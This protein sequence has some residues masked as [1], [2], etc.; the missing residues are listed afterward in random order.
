M[1]I[2]IYLKGKEEPIIVEEDVSMGDTWVN[3]DEEG[4]TIYLPFNLVEKVIE[5]DEE[6][7]E[8]EEERGEEEE[9]ETRKPKRKG[10]LSGM[11]R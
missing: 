10:I 11:F 1:T 4:K 7:E 9:L 8:D 5:F 2:K 6:E 3:W